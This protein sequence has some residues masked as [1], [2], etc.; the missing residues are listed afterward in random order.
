[1]LRCARARLLD[2]ADDNIAAF[3]W[4]LADLLM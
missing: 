3:G 4:R 1:M 2:P